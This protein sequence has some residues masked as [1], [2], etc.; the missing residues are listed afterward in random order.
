MGAE[1]PLFTIFVA[2]MASPEIHLAAGGSVVFPVSLLVEGPV[3]MLLAAGTALATDREALRRLRYWTGILSLALTAIHITIAFTPLFDLLAREFMGIPEEVL[4][5]A[6]I[7]LQIMTPWT[8]SIAW[9]RLHQG[10]LIRLE[11][12]RAVAWGTALRLALLLTVFFVGR[13][14]TSMSGIVLG[15]TAVAIAVF[16]EAVF[17]HVAARTAI[18]DKLPLTSSTSPPSLDSFLRFY[19]PLA[20]TPFLTLLIQPAGAAAMARLAMPVVSLAA[21][22]AVHGLVFL[23]RS[24]G[25][26]FHEVVVALA[27]RPG[28]RAALGRFAGLLALATSGILLILGL[29]PAGPWWFGTVSGLNPELTKTATTAALLA[30]PMPAWQAAQSLYSGRLVNAH[31]TGAIP[32]AVLLY[33]LLALAG[34]FLLATTIHPDPGIH[35]ILPVL[36]IAGLAQ[37]LY[38]AWRS[39]SHS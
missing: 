18:Q 35:G 21:W 9:R 4:D 13:S 17:A 29:T 23:L 27:G 14:L 39:R 28:G 19:I 24:T 38:L 8:A 7:G 11:S 6:R 26:A 34:F 12:A 31:T 32:Q 3:I 2:R 22:P 15:S 25:F 10:V 30:F 16:A 5:P 37:T 20:L 1:M 33:V 36:V